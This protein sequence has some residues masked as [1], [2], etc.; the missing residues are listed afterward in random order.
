[1]TLELR[2]LGMALARGEQSSRALVEDCLARI[3]AGN[4]RL[5]AFVR[6]FADTARA[7]ADRADAAAARGTSLGPLHGIPFAMKDL[8]DIAGHEPSFGS[9]CY[10]RG[11]AE[12]TAPAVARLQASGAVLL[13]VTHM[14][15][16]AIGGWGTNYSMG[17]P[18]N[19]CDPDHHRVPGGSSSGS[20]VAVAAGMVPFAIGSDT[21]GSVRIPASLCGVVGLKPSSGLIPLDGIAPL[22]P[23]FDTLGPLTL[24]TADAG[25]VADIMAGAAPDAC[26]PE[27]PHRLGFVPLDYLDPIDA[28]IVAGYLALIATLRARGHEL[29]PVHLPLPAAEYQRR[30]GLIVAHEIYTR[31]ADVA[32]DNTLPV[33]PHVRQRVLSGAGVGV[34]EHAEL[35]ARR[36]AAIARMKDVMASTPLIL[37]PTT[38]LRARRIEDVDEATIPL[39]RYTRIANYFDLAAISL[40]LPGQRLPAGLQIMAA[41]GSDRALIAAACALASVLAGVEERAVEEL[42]F[43]S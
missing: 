33:D 29:E 40:P 31:L 43:T 16:F 39:S 3:D 21:G 17:T 6:V 14:V 22:S 30:N 42:Q 27:L 36:E 26:V 35:L 10:G 11:V 2:D 20:A 24:T 13:G 7:E 15:E 41:R 19:P 34:A 37:M 38:P 12:H 9:R 28:G 32:L 25:L 23:T 18:R 8:A 5:H 1:M 4:R